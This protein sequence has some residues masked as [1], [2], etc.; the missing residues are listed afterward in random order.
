MSQDLRDFLD[1]T[2]NLRNSMVKR[3][4]LIAS[5][6][7]TVSLNTN[8]DELE[9]QINKHLE[10]AYCLSLNQDFSLLKHPI[11]KS[12]SARSDEKPSQVENFRLQRL[13]YSKKAK[14]SSADIYDFL[15]SQ[16]IIK[17]IKLKLPKVKNPYLSQ[18]SPIPRYKRPK[19]IQLIVDK[20]LPL[21]KISRIEKAYAKDQKLV[22]N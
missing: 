16:P 2:K 13:A 14:A 7:T 19:K 1:R 8:Y 18:M 6:P 20:T 17:P 11:S 9:L 3:A 4:D 22:L 21:L 5:S 15:S 10:K 12:V